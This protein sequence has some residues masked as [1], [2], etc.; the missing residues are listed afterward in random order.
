MSI[1]V[2]M[3]LKAILNPTFQ[4]SSH[5]TPTIKVRV[6]KDSYV[7]EKALI[8]PVRNLFGK[9]VNWVHDGYTTLQL[10]PSGNWMN[11]ANIN[12]FWKASTEG[13][14][15]IYDVTVDVYTD[16]NVILEFF[17]WYRSH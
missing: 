4:G 2:G 5:F 16:K 9:F 6:P 7:D 13:N 11:V 14:S 3:A 15:D 10:P 1:S 12:K 8:K 17:S